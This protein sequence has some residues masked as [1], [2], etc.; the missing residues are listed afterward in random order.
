MSINANRPT[1]TYENIA[2]F[3]SNSP[4][5][6]TSSNYATGISFVPL[7]ESVEISFGVDE[8][9]VRE[10]GNKQFSEKQ[11]YLAPDVNFSLS[12]KESFTGLFNQLT[13]TDTDTN[14]YVAIKDKKSEGVITVIIDPKLQKKLRSIIPSLISN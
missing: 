11:S 14:F 3:Q 12:K 5:H 8:K 6:D 1:I 7:A 9:L 2:V 10:I 4:A 13:G